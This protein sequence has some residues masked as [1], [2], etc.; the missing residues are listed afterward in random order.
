LKT[1]VIAAAAHGYCVLAEM[2]KNFGR[3]SIIP[4]QGSI[5]PSTG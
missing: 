1:T 2:M 5:F 4:E 3:G